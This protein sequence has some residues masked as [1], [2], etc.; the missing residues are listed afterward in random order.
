[1]EAVGEV[2]S[3][4]EEVVLTWSTIVELLVVL[5]L[6]DFRKLV[7]DPLK[8]PFL[9]RQ[10][11]HV[12]S[13]HSISCLADDLVHDWQDL[14]QSVRCELPNHGDSVD[15]FDD[16][17]VELSTLTVSHCE[18]SD[19]F[20][21]V[22]PSVVANSQ[23][24]NHLQRLSRET[25]DQVLKFVFFWDG[26]VPNVTVESVEKTIKRFLAIKLGC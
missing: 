19:R 13:R 5:V 9:Q 12:A 6:L 25:P 1:M 21:Q 3:Q 10:I 26:L 14:N 18:N 24:T 4:S 8:D 2:V 7:Q 11:A 20:V 17:L 15:L 22:S 23:T 16:D